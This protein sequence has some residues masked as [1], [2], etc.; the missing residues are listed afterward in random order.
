MIGCVGF[1]IRPVTQFDCPLITA[2]P[3]APVKVKRYMGL[4]SYSF[5]H[6]TAVPP[7]VTDTV[8][9][10]VRGTEIGGLKLYDA[11]QIT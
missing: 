10:M 5:F 1:S 7:W 11:L 9:N 8:R 2:V 6:V 4:L 3:P